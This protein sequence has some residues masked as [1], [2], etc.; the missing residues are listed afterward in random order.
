MSYF[1]SLTTSPKRLP[2]L[3]PTLTSL[4]GQKNIK[5]E[6]IIVNL[7]TVFKRTKEIYPDPASVF[8]QED[9]TFFA[10]NGVVFHQVQEDL[11]PITKLVGGVQY[12][13]K[14]STAPTSSYIVTVDDDI[15]YNAHILDAYDIC[16]Q[17]DLGTFAMGFA[18]FVF[19]PQPPYIS[20]VYGSRP[21]NV[22]EGYLSV[23]YNTQWFDNERFPRYLDVCLKNA[24]C[25]SS[26]DFVISNWLS[27]ISVVRLLISFPF[28]SR[29]I[30]WHQ[31]CI[32]DYGN[33]E[34]ALHNGAA[35]G[36]N[37]VDRYRKSK[38]FLKTVNLL[39]QEFS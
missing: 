28:V 32:L 33:Q 25:F 8:S 22:V 4:I 2:L 9:L 35:C 10:D 20:A 30:M 1:F 39:S 24:E 21:C 5:A 16:I 12:I 11:G 38:L 17:R 19:V 6:K 14:V 23:C 36:M 7:P 18:G 26:D 27:Q 37:N 29:E 3:K 31:K 13:K 15:F 34:D